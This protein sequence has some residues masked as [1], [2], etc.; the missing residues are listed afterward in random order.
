MNHES[1]LQP[2]C[3]VLVRRSAVC[4]DNDDGKLRNKTSYLTRNC[5]LI[6]QRRLFA[7]FFLRICIFVYIGSFA[8]KIVASV[9]ADTL[10]VYDCAFEE[11]NV[12]MPAGESYVVDMQDV[13]R[14]HYGAADN[15][16]PVNIG[17]IVVVRQEL[18]ASC[19]VFVP[20]VVRQFLADAGVECVLCDSLE[21]EVV[22][23][24]WQDFVVLA[25]GSVSC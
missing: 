1:W 8:L 24:S 21:N 13:L 11:P 12:V 18:F 9:T 5:V 3:F 17:D 2:F 7:C 25:N 20:A 4:E 14:F 6:W 15:R 23:R 16:C 19:F 10:A 22:Q